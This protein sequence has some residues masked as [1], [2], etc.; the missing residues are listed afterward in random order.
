MIKIARY[1][2][3]IRDKRNSKRIKLRVQLA[4]KIEGF[5]IGYAESARVSE[6]VAELEV[7]RALQDIINQ[8]N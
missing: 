7:K 8:M 1:C 5:V 4:Q 6:Q 3:S 2:I